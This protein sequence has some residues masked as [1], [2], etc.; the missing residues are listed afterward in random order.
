MLSRTVN[1]MNCPICNRDMKSKE[2]HFISVYAK[3]FIC[4]FHSF[5]YNNETKT[6]K[7][8][9]DNRSFVYD[10]QTNKWEEL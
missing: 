8:L 10:F 5:K 4:G 7:S 6:Y 9:Y 3:E 1:I 2:Y